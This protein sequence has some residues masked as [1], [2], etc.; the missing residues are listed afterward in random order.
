MANIALFYFIA[1]VIERLMELIDWILS[2]F[3]EKKEGQE[4]IK[5]QSC[6]MI[7]MWILASGL[8]FLFCYFL[9]LNLMKRLDLV[10][11]PWL[12]KVFSAVVIGSGTKPIHD[13][14]SLMEKG[15][16]SSL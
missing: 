3:I 8:A 5:R 9:D 16:K 2:F 12:D 14:I 6:K 1:Q 15:K 13:I 11:N 7:F 10:I 4:A